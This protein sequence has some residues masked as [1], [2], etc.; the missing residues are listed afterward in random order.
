MSVSIYRENNS[1]GKIAT[2][3]H[4]YS[5]LTR[6]QLFNGI[7]IVIA[8]RECG[9]IKFL[10]SLGVK[11][12]NIIA[13]DIDP[14][15]RANAKALGVVVSPRETIQDTVTWAFAKHGRKIVS[16]NADL[17][18][19]VINGTP[20]LKAVLENIRAMIGGKSSQIIVMFTYAR[21][22]DSVVI[23]GT[24]NHMSARLAHICLE[25]GLSLGHSVNGYGNDYVSYTKSR[26]GAPMSMLAVQPFRSYHSK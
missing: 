9:D 6:V 12:K 26:T 16:V 1:P 15:A 8:S 7:H 17:C 25:T 24:D 13:C 21:Y 5:L 11:A 19:S 14:V 20:I 4:G 18:M 10:L 22:R 3:A 2:R 23:K